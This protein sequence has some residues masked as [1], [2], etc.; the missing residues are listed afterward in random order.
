MPRAFVLMRSEPAAR[1]DAI[2]AGFEALGFT[3]GAHHPDDVARSDDVLLTWNLVAHRER[4]ARRFA[5]EG[6][7]LVVMENGYLEKAHDI[8]GYYALARDGHNGAGA[9]PSGGPER[10]DALDVILAPLRQ[11]GTHILICGQRGIGAPEERCSPGWAI[12][13]VSR[14][15]ARTTR[16]LLFRPHPHGRERFP[17][18]QGVEISPEGRP[19]VEDLCGCWACVVWNSNA[20]T[21]A[22]I[23]GV[24]VFFEG[25]HIITAQGCRR[26]FAALDMYL[27][28][29]DRWGWENNRLAALRRLAWGQ[30]TLDEIATGQPFARLLDGTP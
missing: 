28:G 9:F 7:R 23:A 15:R 20:A 16:P 30:W 22:L 5:A 14:L 10:F 12:D 3:V 18:P 4:V 21:Q 6:G 1:T 29:S 24:P 2:R 19:L 13:V 11:V 27:A 26:D 17:W 25:P 8:R